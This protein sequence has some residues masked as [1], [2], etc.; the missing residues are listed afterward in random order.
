MAAQSQGIAGG[1]Q[2][3]LTKP[4]VERK[5]HTTVAAQLLERSWNAVREAA[6]PDRIF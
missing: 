6:A 3:R 2:H 4:T 1:P 5:L